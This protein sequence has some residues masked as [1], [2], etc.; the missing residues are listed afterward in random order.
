MSQGM[1]SP[2]AT[3]CSPGLLPGSVFIFIRWELRP[4]EP[5]AAERTKEE[6][7]QIFNKSSHRGRMS[8]V[9]VSVG[10]WMG[11]RTLSGRVMGHGQG[12]GTEQVGEIN[13]SHVCLL[14]GWMAWHNKV[15]N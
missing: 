12:N 4:E 1:R 10:E 8:S 15:R 7:R 14:L 6:P 3:N 11:G 13:I 5:A 2:S 9:I